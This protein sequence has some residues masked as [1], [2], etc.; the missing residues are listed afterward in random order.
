[1]VSDAP[2]VGDLIDRLGE[3]LKTEGGQMVI[4]V[5]PTERWTVS[6]DSLD[7]DAVTATGGTGAFGSGPTLRAALENLLEEAGW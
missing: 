5:D 4:T 1:M 7:H 2:T 6:A 3:R